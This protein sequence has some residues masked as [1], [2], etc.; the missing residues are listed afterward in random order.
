MTN[1][2]HC[3]DDFLFIH[4]D[5][6]KRIDAGRLNGIGGRLEP[7]E[8]FLKAAIRETEEET[9]YNVSPEDVRLAGVVKL[10]GG[11]SEDWV[12]CF[13]KIKVPN[14]EIPKGYKSED[15]DLVWINKDR[16]LDSDFE[17]V[18]DINYC[19][20]DIVSGKELFFMTAKVGDDQK[21]YEVSVTK[22]GV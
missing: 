22:L 17:L 11:Y 2:I 9:G 18:D 5:Q 7:G 21:I 6:N 4:R 20:K 1:F 16:V 12:M 10:E 13:F 15:G 19:F 14:K 8:D 3:G